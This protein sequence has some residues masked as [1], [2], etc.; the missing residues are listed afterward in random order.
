MSR[1]TFDARR[2][3]AGVVAR[4]RQH[5]V[6]VSAAGRV[7][8]APEIVSGAATDESLM[9]GQQLLPTAWSADGRF[10]AYM[11]NSAGSPDIWILPLTGDRKPFAFAQTPASERNPAFAPDGKWM[12]YQSSE[13]G[14]WQVYV[15]PFPATGGKYLVSIDGGEQPSWRADGKELFFLGSGAKMMAATTDTTREF[16]AGAPQALFSTNASTTSNDA[17]VW[18]EQGRE[19]VPGEHEN[20]AVEQHAAD[21]R[22]QL[23]C[24]DSEIATSRGLSNLTSVTAAFGIAAR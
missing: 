2:Y 6:P 19:T 23:A 5:R 21:G 22:R 13:T 11:R 3:I 7:E 10:L 1:L 8:P 9:K 12:A 24:H 4:R 18:S 16:E 14:Q 20:R 15:Q 17:S